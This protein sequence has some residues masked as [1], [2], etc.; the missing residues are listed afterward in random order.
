MGDHK[1]VMTLD[2]VKLQRDIRT[3]IH[4][5]FVGKTLDYQ[6]RAVSER[7]TQNSEWA[8]FFLGRVR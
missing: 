4:K 5:E 7:V 3:K 8:N 6:L 2:C 1:Q